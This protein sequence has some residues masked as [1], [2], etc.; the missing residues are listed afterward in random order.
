MRSHEISTMP[1]FEQGVN[2][3][4]RFGTTLVISMLLIVTVGFQAL[5]SKSGAQST[6]ETAEPARPVVIDLQTRVADLETRVAALDGGS[7]AASA[8]STQAAQ[9]TQP[10][11]TTQPAPTIEPTPTPQPSATAEPQTYTV[12]GDFVV[13]FPPDNLCGAT[14]IAMGTASA[15]PS[16]VVVYDEAN[17]VIGTVKVD[18]F[19]IESL[20]PDLNSH[21]RYPFEVTGLP[22]SN[23]YTFEVDA[24]AEWTR[25]LPSRTY[26]FE[27]LEQAG[28][29]VHLSDD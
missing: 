14:D 21:C 6:E 4:R 9:T 20:D 16:G 22:R 5:S 3:L 8:P 7:A 15:L 29:Q 19:E 18:E 13:T 23:F 28:W 1:T 2:A 24:G 10:T 11:S 27:E 12:T 25:Q 26:S 17:E